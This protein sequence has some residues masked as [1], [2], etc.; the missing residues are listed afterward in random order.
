MLESVKIEKVLFL[1]IETVPQVYKF[2]DLDEKTADLYQQKT[3]WLKKEDTTDEEI[4]ERAGIYAEFGK[5]VCITCGIVQMHMGKA[6]VRLKS[7]A[8]DDEVKLLNNFIDMCNE[9]FGSGKLMLMCGHNAKEFDFPFI[10]RRILINGLK[11]PGPLNIAGKKPW[12]IAHLDTMELWKFGDY[13]HYTSLNLLTHILGIPS[14]KQDIDGSEVA[15]VY[16]KEKD[17]YRIIRYCENDTIAVAQL[18][19]RF[20]NLPIL[21]EQNILQVNLQLENS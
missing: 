3:K 2:K 13:K 19:L 4:Y 12:E 16:Y 7:F 1:D 9:S 17:I 14:P 18:L 5:I 8:D 20:H 10:A 15:N 6:S 21:E 11:L